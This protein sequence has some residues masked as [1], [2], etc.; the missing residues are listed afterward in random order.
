MIKNGRKNTIFIIT[1][2]LIT[3]LFKPLW[4]FN[5]QNLGIPGDDMSHWLH[6]ATIAFDFDLDYTNDYKLESNIFN[7]ETNVPSHPPG[8][9]YI[10]S[11]FVFLFSQLDKV[12]NLPV[13]NTR[14]NPVKSFAYIGFFVSGLFYTYIG[15]KL[16][17]KTVKKYNNDFSGLLIFC[18]LISTLVHF[19]TTRFLMSHAVEF[20]LCCVLIYI[21]ENE[22]NEYFKTPDITKLFFTYFCLSITRP[23]TFL[24]SL[25]LILFYKRKFVFDRKN[26]IT[27]IIQ[28]FGFSIFYI[29]LSRLLYQKSYI[30]L[31]TY[32][33][34]AEEYYATL[35][36]EQLLNGFLKLPNLFFS[37]NMGIVYSSPIIFI[38]LI[39]FF[40]KLLTDNINFSDKVII[41]LFFGASTVPLLIWQGREVAYGQRL[42]IGIIPICILISCKYVTNK[43]LKLLTKSLTLFSFLGYLFFYSSE[44]LTLRPGTTL[45]NTQVGYTSENYYVELLKAF[46]DYEA[47]LSALLRNIYSV[48]IFKFFDLRNFI[49][50][51][52]LLS[53]F[54]VQKVEK[55]LSFTDLYYNLDSSYLIIINLVIFLFSFFYTKIIFDV[56]K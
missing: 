9:G 45:W 31:N 21:F 5:N 49:S 2:F 42:L 20:F 55:F 8:A 16:L 48:D 46:L 43:P 25:I 18:G 28:T 52:S 14:T 1:F 30:F 38:A 4:L 23:S 47:I 3:L 32:G 51:S 10:A 37:P 7:P 54:S 56:R 19:V 39:V 33:N 36:F 53:N 34:Q 24:Y 26:T 27:Y 40:T 35:N 22:E 13:E 15:T 12:I 29:F 17:S 44:R 50:D 11:P 41:F 6:S